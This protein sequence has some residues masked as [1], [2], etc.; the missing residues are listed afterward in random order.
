MNENFD[1]SSL[2]SVLSSGQ[3]VLIV[4]PANPDLDRLA[5][6]LSLYLALK[7]AGKETV[8]V[9]SQPMTVEFSQLVG[10][11]KISNQVNS[12]DLVV[13][14]DYQKD[15]IEKVS[16]NIKDNKFN[17]VIQSKPGFPLL[18]PKTI[19]YSFSGGGADLI[20]VIGAQKLEDLGDLY[21]KAKELYQEKPVVNIDYQEQNTR[22]GKINLVFN[23]ASSYSEL[24]AMILKGLNLD[25]D[26]DIANNLFLGI[27]SAT[28]NFQAADISPEA[29]EMA[30]WCLRSGAKKKEVKPLKE[31]EATAS[32]SPSP[33]WLSPKIYNSKRV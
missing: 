6:S 22:F 27:Q 13:S 5:A 1:L 3:A 23:Q 12:R 32:V 11:D 31:K 9:C 7:K 14:F 24:T 17:L 21:E 30:A 29:F 26:A 18:D 2:S 25:V 10:V 16:Y 15:S 8:V 28:N 20:F 19:N 4:V 33:D